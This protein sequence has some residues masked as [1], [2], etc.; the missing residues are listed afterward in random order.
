MAEIQSQCCRKPSQSENAA[1]LPDNPKHPSVG[2][3]PDYIP[4]VEGIIEEIEGPA[5]KDAAV[6]RGLAYDAGL[7]F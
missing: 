6:M 3:L 2:V 7:T 5:R 1:N 4:D